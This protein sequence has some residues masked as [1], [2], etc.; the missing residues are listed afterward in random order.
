[1]KKS[2][3]R[4]PQST[5]LNLSAMTICALAGLTLLSAAEEAD[6]GYTCV[7]NSTQVGS[8]ITTELVATSGGSSTICV[9]RKTLATGVQEYDVSAS[10]TSTQ[11][12]A[13]NGGYYAYTSA[14]PPIG[15]PEF[16]ALCTQNGQGGVC[17]ASN[18]G[19]MDGIDVVDCGVT[20]D[21]Y[22]LPEPA[23]P[24]VPVTLTTI[25]TFTYSLQ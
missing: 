15:S 4:P 5:R 22:N 1:M 9:A 2:L 11:V 14:A 3:Q 8:T 24:L 21:S 12:G 23:L 20:D 19:T 13:T 16:Q 17:S 6:A 18:S 25:C 10:V 7:S